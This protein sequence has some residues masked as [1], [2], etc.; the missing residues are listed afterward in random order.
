MGLIL[1]IAIALPLAVYLV[2][3]QQQLRGRA[4]P[5]T[6][7]CFSTTT[8]CATTPISANV[9]TDLSVNVLINTG[10]NQVSAAQI[11][12]TFQSN[13][14][15]ATSITPGPLLSSELVKGQTGSGFASIT[16]GSQPNQP[17]TGTGIIAVIKFSPQN[18]GTATLVFD[19]A[20]T[21]AS[22]IQ[23]GSN[24]I[25]V[26]GLSQATVTISGG[27]AT[28]PGGPTATPAPGPVCSSLSLSPGA[29]G[30]APFAV[31]FTA[32]GQGKD[33]SI[34]ITKVT[35]NFGDGGIE[36]MSDTGGIGTNQVAA[37]KTHSFAAPGTF[38]AFAVLTDSNGATSDQNTCTQ[39]IN[40]STGPTGGAGGGGGVGGATPAAGTGTPT[41]TIGAGATASPTQ[42]VTKGGQPIPKAGDTIS[43]IILGVGGALLLIGGA[44]LFL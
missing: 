18:N 38:K 23:E 39:T 40:V 9:G 34:K 31:T 29:S 41:P 22:G 20:K 24:V 14:L 42:P 30:T 10:T 7:L 16:V 37:Q 25:T 33:S 3:Q 4:A 32:N 6:T 35:F 27:P 1:L 21:Q 15:N 44:L 28:T 2:Q 12:A 8:T 17:A 13:L 5:A 11:Y 43:T 36:S 26:G 19:P